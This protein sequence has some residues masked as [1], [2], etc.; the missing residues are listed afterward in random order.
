MTHTTD[1]TTQR[2]AAAWLQAGNRS[3]QAPS[4]LHQSKCA[5]ESCAG[6]AFAE[7]LTSDGKQ[8]LCWK[9]FESVRTEVSQ[10]KG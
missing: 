2:I 1:T 6:L 4:F 5:V 3:P 7:I 8:N 9:H 10:A